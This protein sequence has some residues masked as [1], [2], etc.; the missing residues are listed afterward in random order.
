LLLDEVDNVKIDRQLRAIF[1]AGHMAGGQVPRV[2]LGETVFFPVYGPLAMAGIGT[3]PPTLLSRS[4][5]IHI[6]RSDTK[7]RFHRLEEAASIGMKVEEWATKVNLNHDPDIP[8]KG[9][10]ADNWRVLLA[11]ADS[12]GRGDIAREAA[13][14]FTKEHSF[15]NVKLALLYDIRT[16]F[17]AAEA[18]VLPGHVLI[19]KLINLDNGIADW[20]DHQLT[21]NKLAHILSEFQI[22]NKLQRW[23]ETLYDR[24]VTR[25]YVRGDFEDMW[26]RY[27]TPGGLGVPAP[28]VASVTSVTKKPKKGV[29]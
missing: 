11:I 2:I 12:L 9:R 22:R 8:L 25:C 28:R 27:L 16:V 29:K 21:T 7:P 24:K 20:T 14:K 15:P 10:A 4:L 19:T 26:R 23:P 1:N 13:V 17:D 18:T 5:I 6:H 3:L